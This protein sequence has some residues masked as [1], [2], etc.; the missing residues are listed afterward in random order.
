MNKISLIITLILLFTCGCANT[1]QQKIIPMPAPPVQ[2]IN[3]DYIIH[4]TGGIYLPD[5]EYSN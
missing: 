4:D 5:V 2:N 3:P 1:G